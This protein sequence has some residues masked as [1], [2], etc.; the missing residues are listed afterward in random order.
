LN[1]Y[2]KNDTA[3]LNKI[4]ANDFILINPAGLYQNKK[5]NLLN[6]ADRNI[7]TISVNLDSVNV[8]MTSPNVAVLNA[9]ANFTFK[10]N[11]K[12]MT[13]KNCYQEV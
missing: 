4:L 9:W 2:P 12:Q 7:E 11:R 13:G 1:T 8:R 6:M 10:T 5:D 3:T